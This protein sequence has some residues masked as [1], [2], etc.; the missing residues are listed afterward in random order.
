M[1]VALGALAAP[2]GLP[3]CVLTPHWNYVVWR[4]SFGDLADWLR[5]PDSFERSMDCPH[6]IWP[7]DRKWCL[8]T[9]YSG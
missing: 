6:I 2:P 8:A 4:A 1:A 5:Q 7:R 3:A 9:L